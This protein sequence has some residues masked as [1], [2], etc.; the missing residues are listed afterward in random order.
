MF[1]VSIGSRKIE[2]RGKEGSFYIDSFVELMF[3]A[4][5]EDGKL[6]FLFGFI[7]KRRGDLWVG[8][9]FFGFL[10]PE[11]DE[12]EVETLQLLVHS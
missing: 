3:H 10:F 2:E 5:P 4:I 8:N 11:I 1:D 6:G 12:I 7:E 9:I